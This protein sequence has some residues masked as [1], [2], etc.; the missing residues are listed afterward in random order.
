[1]RP[2]VPDLRTDDHGEERWRDKLSEIGVRIMKLRRYKG[3]NRYDLA[4]HL[5]CSYNL[6][7]LVETGQRAPSFFRFLQLAE[8]LGV[9]PGELMDGPRLE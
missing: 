4:T 2:I 7:Y 8:V 9:H 3:W 1:M 6:V 5:D